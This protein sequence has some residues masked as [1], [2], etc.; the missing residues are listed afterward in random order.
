MS[1]Q[2]KNRILVYNDS[3]FITSQTFIYYQVQS[4]SEK[5]EVDLLG[6][7]FVNP[8]GYEIDSFRTH[9][10]SLPKNTFEKAVS[11]M[12]RESF[13]SPLNLNPRSYVRLRKL[14]KKNS[15]SAIHA[16][17]G[18]NGLNILKHAKKCRLPLVVTF[19]GY[20]ASRMLSDE[21]YKNRLPELFEY[22]SAIILV[23]RH[24]ID[25]LNLERWLDKVKIIPCTVDP[26]V[27]E[28][29][30]ENSTNGIKILHSGRLVDKKG[31]P[32]LIKVF[33]NLRRRYDNIELHIVGDGKKLER[34]KE[35]VQKFKLDKNVTFYGAVSHDDVKNILSKADIFVLN[36]RVGDDGDMEG[37]PVTLLEAMCSKV[38]VISTRHAGIPDVIEDGVNGLLVDERDNEGLEDALSTFIENPELRQNCAENARNTVLKEYTV[39]RMKEKLI[40]V[41]Q[42][43]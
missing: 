34:C 3:F 17:F 16:H 28:I 9:E 30:R 43:L 5:Y 35:L 42:S 7:K 40:Q 2:K 8:H 26:D 20:D 23:S 41:F 29:R 32:D 38:P 19:H 10:I 25:N 36:S 27:F 18:Y 24:M 11:K 12:Y 33:R 4:L 14:F 6:L 1:D 31:V 37:T 13:N 39:D 15:Y 21:T 22:A